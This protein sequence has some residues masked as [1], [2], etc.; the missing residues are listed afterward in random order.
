V[1][2]IDRQKVGDDVV[3]G[4]IVADWD[5]MSIDLR[6]DD[7]R[8]KLAQRFISEHCLKLLD[9][10]RTIGMAKGMFYSAINDNKFVLVDVLK[11]VDQFV[12]PGMVRDLF[13]AAVPTQEVIK[14]DIINDSLID[15]ISAGHGNFAGSLILKPSRFRMLEQKGTKPTPLYIEVQH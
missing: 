8:S 6:A 15:L 7:E 12:G 4:F 13:G 5:G 10:M 11:G 3:C 9:V 14:V 1:A 2:S